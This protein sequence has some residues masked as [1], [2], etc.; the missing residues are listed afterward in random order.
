MPEPP[1]FGRVFGTLDLCLGLV[2]LS[3]KAPSPS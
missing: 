3:L 2:A 1:L